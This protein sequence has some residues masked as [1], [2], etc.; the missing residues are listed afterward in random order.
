MV[1]LVIFGALFSYHLPGEL[2]A[3]SRSGEGPTSSS[4][5]SCMHGHMAKDITTLP[6]WW[7][8]METSL[9]KLIEI[10]EEN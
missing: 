9:R 6:W 4:A 1:F 10:R 3:S 2:A 7:L 8:G 5:K